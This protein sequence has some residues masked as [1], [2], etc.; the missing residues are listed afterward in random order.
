MLIHTVALMSF[1]FMMSTSGGLDIGLLLLS[2]LLGNLVQ[3]QSS[4]H[5][6]TACFAELN[7]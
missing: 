6:S 2:L 5:A 7:V 3:S 4:L 1:A